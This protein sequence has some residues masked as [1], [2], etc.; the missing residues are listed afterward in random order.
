MKIID[1]LP[2]TLFQTIHEQALLALSTRDNAAY[3]VGMHTANMKINGEIR[4]TIIPPLDLYISKVTE[5]GVVSSDIDYRISYNHTTFPLGHVY[6]QSG[7]LCLGNI[8]VQPYVSQ[9]NLM[10]PLETLFLYNDKN[11]NHGGAQLP[12]TVEQHEEVLVWANEVDV[13]VNAN[14]D[15]YLKNDTLWDMCAQLLEKYDTDTAY[16]KANG[17][18]N[19]IFREDGKQ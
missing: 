8:P 9:Y 5:K 19:I 13:T 2:E 12:I 7:Y 14:A 15:Q 10:A 1:K 17:L 6:G 16:D 11:I 3:H 4:K 18:F